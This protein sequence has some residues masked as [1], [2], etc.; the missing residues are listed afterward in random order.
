MTS[1]HQ[2]AIGSEQSF[3]NED[4]REERSLTIIS[5]LL[6]GLI[7]DLHINTEGK[8]LLRKQSRGGDLR[9]RSQ[10]EVRLVDGPIVPASIGVVSELAELVVG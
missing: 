6:D 5:V 9:V 8:F 7:G 2:L 3:L 10:L 4:R 1:Q